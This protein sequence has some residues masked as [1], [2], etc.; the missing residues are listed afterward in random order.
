MAE[1]ITGQTDLV[2]LLVKIR[3]V[4]IQMK[5]MKYCNNIFDI[6]YYYYSLNTAQKL[7][8]QELHPNL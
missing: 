4:I 6:F 3:G 2:F 8:E 5:S 7:S 1:R